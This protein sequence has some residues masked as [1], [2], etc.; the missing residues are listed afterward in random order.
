V[1]ARRTAYATLL[2]PS[3]L[4]ASHLGAQTSTRVPE[5]KAPPRIS[6][7]SFLVEEA[8]NQEAGVVQHISNFRRAPDGAWLFTFTQEW[9]APSQRHQL[10]YT[11]PLLSTPESGRGPGDVML[12]YRY[13][14]LGKD[15]ERV[16]LAPRISAILPTGSSRDGRG[17]G[18]IGVQLE[19]PLSVAL[20][21]KLVTHWNAGGTLTHARALGGLT[22]A[23]RGVNAAAS[24]IWLVAPTV[25]LMLESVWELVESLDDAGARG[26]EEHFVVLPGVRAALNLSSGM[27]IVPGIGM[28]IGIGPAR[29]QRD[30]FLYLSVEHAFR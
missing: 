1:T 4:A 19:L 9:P 21:D 2:L 18:G 25:N 23:T 12:N 22:R 20:S 16:W 10:S 26:A 11:L 5:A 13:Q 17:A 3:L 7:N 15:D 6:D 29:G 24:A 30:L 27:Q 14:A 28:P 8:Y